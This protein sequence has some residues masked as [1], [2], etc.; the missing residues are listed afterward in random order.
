MRAARPVFPSPRVPFC[1]DAWRYRACFHGVRRGRTNRG[2][3][4]VEILIATAI[5]VAVLAIGVPSLNAMRGPYALTSAADQVAAHVALARQ[6]AVARNTRYRITYGTTTY[7]LERET[8]TN[9][10][11]A[12]GA[13]IGLPSGASIGSVSPAAPI[14][15]SRGMLTADVTVPVSVTGTGTR[16]VTI[17]VLGRTTIS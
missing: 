10:F 5:L 15:N 14:F 12:D 8:T 3:S 4:I 16:T 9:V 13:A 1:A 17:N 6:K 7:Q 2:T 11:V